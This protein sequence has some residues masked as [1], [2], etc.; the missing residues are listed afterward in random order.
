MIKLSNYEKRLKELFKEN[1]YID[2]VSLWH[3]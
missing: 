3:I 2:F 1:D